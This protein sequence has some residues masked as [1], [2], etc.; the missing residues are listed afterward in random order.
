MKK[1]IILFVVLI[2]LI[3]GV[4]TSLFSQDY[5]YNSDINYL[6]LAPKSFLF[7]VDCS[8][9]MNRKFSMNDPTKKIDIIKYWLPYYI[10]K[11]PCD[12]PVGMRIYGHDDEMVTFSKCDNSDIVFYVGTENRKKINDDLEKIKYSKEIPLGLS[13]NKA[14]MYDFNNIGGMKE[15]ILITDNLGNCKSKPCQL[16]GKLLK[17]RNDIRINVIALGVKS[18]TIE[19]SLKFIALESG[20]KYFN[21]NNEKEIEA[22]LNDIILKKS[23]S[24]KEFSKSYE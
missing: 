12:I 5:S 21:V 9:R 17:D 11:L 19:K 2:G 20:G 1:Y 7:V 22:A 13:L 8:K 10:N 16:I 23:P 18:N 3:L 14:I 15:I 6:D 24:E 4:N